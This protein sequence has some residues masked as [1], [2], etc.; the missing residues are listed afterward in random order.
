MSPPMSAVNAR[1]TRAKYSDICPELHTLIAPSSS[2]SDSSGTM[3]SGSTSILVPSPEQSGQAPKGELNENDRG[4][5]SSKL[6][7]SR[8]QAKCSLTVRSRFGSSSAR[9]TKSRVMM[10]PDNSKA[11]STES[12]IRCRALSR[13]TSRSTT[14]S[15]VCFSC[16]FSVGGSDNGYSTP[17]TRTRA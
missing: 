10:P 17:S 11:V 1:S 13:T 12:V 8:G 2:E 5:N 7:P 16:F 3:S 6:N 14:T 4:S 9:S 15:M